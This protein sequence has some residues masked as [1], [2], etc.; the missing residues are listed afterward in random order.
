MR[1]QNS[2]FHDVVKR[3]PWPVFDGLVE[4]H[5]ADARV[6]KLRTKD[7]L[8]AILYGQLAGAR[9]IRE[10]TTG[11]ESHSARL[12]HLGARPIAR[13]TLADANA[14]RSYKVFAGLF[15]TM[16]Q[17]AGRGWSLSS[18]LT[19]GSCDGR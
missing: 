12:Y 16:V 2:V 3:I 7:Q 14:N 15:G 1:H 13:S 17:Q 10:I 19:R 5:G 9:S 18:G 6:R 8:I 4:A 11:L